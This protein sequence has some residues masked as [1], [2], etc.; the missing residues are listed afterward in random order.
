[1]LISINLIQILN[2]WIAVVN[3]RTSQNRDLE[4]IEIFRSWLYQQAKSTP[5]SHLLQKLPRI[6]A[7]VTV[8]LAGVNCQPALGA[9]LDL[10]LNQS[11]I[12]RNQP[13]S[14]TSPC[15]IGLPT[16]CTSTYQPIDLWVKLAI[17]DDN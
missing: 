3:A 4:P 15:K 1:M 9:D 14:S 8:N 5:R 13:V 10:S 2:L 11:L 16:S 6:F 12:D 7:I 17:S